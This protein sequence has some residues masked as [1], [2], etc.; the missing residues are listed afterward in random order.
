MK[1]GRRCR[2]AGCRGGCRE[3]ALNRTGRAVAL[4]VVEVTLSAVPAGANALPASRPSG[5]ATA[6]RAAVPR[7]GAYTSTVAAT[8]ADLQQWWGQQFPR[9]Y[10]TKYMPVP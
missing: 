10:G 5:G 4:V 8:I 7:S 2:M 1:D 3:S 6:I 9:V